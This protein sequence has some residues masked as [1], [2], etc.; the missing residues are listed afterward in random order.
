[1]KAWKRN[2]AGMILGCCLAAS[3]GGCAFCRTD[4]GFVISS[5]WS[6]EY[7]RV[8]WLAF[9]AN[10]DADECS[11]E[12]KR[13]DVTTCKK[14][15]CAFSDDK[16]PTPSDESN[17]PEL[18]PWRSRL[19]SYRLGSRIFHSKELSEDPTVSEPT[20]LSS[21]ATVLSK[22]SLP[23]VP[24]PPPPDTGEEKASCLRQSSEACKTSEDK[25]DMEITI[26]N[27]GIIPSERKRPDL[28]LE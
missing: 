8:P 22:E 14:S 13:S 21:E 19:K 3:A 26:P 2:I 27:Q 12:S 20:V 25:K 5:Q 9:H 24:P 6:L 4:Q 7:R 17:P 11:Y 23:I 28:V 16:E 15:S 18:L 10:T 1:V